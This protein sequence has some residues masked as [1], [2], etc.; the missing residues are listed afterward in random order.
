MRHSLVTESLFSCKQNR[1]GFVVTMARRLAE[2]SRNSSPAGQ[3]S[4][5][6]SRLE[7]AE[8][9]WLEE[10]STP[11]ARRWN[12]LSDLVPEHLTFSDNANISQEFPSLSS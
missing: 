8:R 7:Q 5:V 1:L 6:E 10:R 2:N 4:K 9:R 12:V 3:L 11:E